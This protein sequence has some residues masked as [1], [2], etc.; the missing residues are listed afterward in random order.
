MPIAEMAMQLQRSAKKEGFV[1]CTKYGRQA[2][3]KNTNLATE[4]PTLHWTYQQ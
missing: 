1:T 4:S 3:F 2:P